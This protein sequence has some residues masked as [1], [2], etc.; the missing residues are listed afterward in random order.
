[1]SE[2]TNYF[3]VQSSAS[4]L[5]ALRAEI[6]GVIPDALVIPNAD[7]FQTLVDE[8]RDA[9]HIPERAYA[10]WSDTPQPAWVVVGRKIPND[11]ADLATLA[12]IGPA[13][14]VAVQQDGSHWKMH[15]QSGDVSWA[16]MVADGSWPGGRL[17]DVDTA[18]LQA[19]T[20]GVGHCADAVTAAFCVMRDG[21]RDCLVPDGANAIRDFLRVPKPY[22]IDQRVMVRDTSGIRLIHE[23][24]PF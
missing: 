24:L 22:L 1:M 8:G 4:N 9:D 23:L 15:L 5:D 16:V 10:A 21:L 6:A 17:T 11:S 19:G 3:A 13:V 18:L 14:F 12:T 20:K 2:Y 7:L